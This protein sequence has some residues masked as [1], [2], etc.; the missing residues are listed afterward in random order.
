MYVHRLGLKAE[1]EECKKNFMDVNVLQMFTHL[2]TLSE[3]LYR[4]L[5]AFFMQYFPASCQRDPAKISVFYYASVHDP[6]RMESYQV[7]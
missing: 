2:N 7:I 3:A 6:L 4:L 1:L 5:L